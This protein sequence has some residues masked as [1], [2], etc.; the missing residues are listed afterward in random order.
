MPTIPDTTSLLASAASTSQPFY[1]AL[2][3]VQNL[4][5]GIFL[6]IMFFLLIVGAAV[7]AMSHVHP[8]AKK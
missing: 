7:A 2:I 4:Y 6:A 1:N 5:V 3:P 8:F